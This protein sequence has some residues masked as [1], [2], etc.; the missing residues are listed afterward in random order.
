MENKLFLDS[1][2]I[3]FRD[4][5][6]S[7]WK[8]LSVMGID[9]A[10][11]GYPVIDALRKV[12]QYTIK[13]IKNIDCEEFRDVSALESLNE[14]THRQHKEDEVFIFDVL[15]C[16]SGID[17]DFD[18]LSINSIDKLKMLFVGKTGY[19]GSYGNVCTARIFETFTMTN[20]ITGNLELWAKA[21]MLKT[22]KTE[23]A[24]KV[25]GTIKNK[26]GSISYSMVTKICSIC[27]ADVLSK[28]CLHKAG[29]YYNGH[30]CYN[31]VAN[32]TDVYEWTL[33][34]DN[35]C[36][37]S[38]GTEIDTN[39]YVKISEFNELAETV[40]KLQRSVAY[41]EGII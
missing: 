32:I 25:L 40:K 39:E 14:F 27:G 20:S 4:A 34:G 29:K 41:I 7:V 9:P 12:T 31:N 28:K 6:S 23:E 37:D 19:V 13:D 18:K 8:A 15:L 5:E 3:N 2:M 35:P 33:L 10:G 36:C 16:S 21:Y 11:S 30:L 26:M 17:S 22:D 38:V 1:H 24:I